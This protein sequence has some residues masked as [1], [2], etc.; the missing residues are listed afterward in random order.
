MKGE[1][2][3]SACGATRGRSVDWRCVVPRRS[4]RKCRRRQADRCRSASTGTG[5]TRVLRCVGLGFGMTLLLLRAASSSDFPT[6]NQHSALIL[7]AE[8]DSRLREKREAIL[9]TCM[10]DLLSECKT[11]SLVKRVRI[12]NLHYLFPA[13][14]PK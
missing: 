5:S 11:R 9:G 2:E 4:R 8:V 7:T 13:S 10:Q 3:V 14:E 6:E 1:G 12:V